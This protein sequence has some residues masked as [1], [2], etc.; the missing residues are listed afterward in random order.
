MP[1]GIPIS[2]INKG[3][4][5]KG[6]Q[7]TEKERNR[8]SEFMKTNNPMQNINSRNKVRLRKL[9]TKSPAT[10]LR[11]LLNNP[12]HNPNTIEKMKKTIAEKYDRTGKN[13]SNWQGGK[14]FE[15][16]SKE[17]NKKIKKFIKERDNYTCRE[18]SISKKTGKKLDIHHIDYDKKNNSPENLI[19]LCINCH[20][21]T[22]FNRKQWKKYY[23]TIMKKPQIKGFTE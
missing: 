18:C 3:W 23:K 2:G 16:Y 5:K 19:T 17:F 10:T 20:C 15:P 8:R 9:G 6:N 22:N 1:K 11:N 21:K 14:S 13:N 7:P 12:M 4:F